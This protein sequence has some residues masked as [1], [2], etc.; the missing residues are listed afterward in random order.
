MRVLEVQISA[1]LEEIRD[2]GFGQDVFEN[3]PPN[4][5]VFS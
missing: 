4:G 2:N 1:H 3:S 5:A